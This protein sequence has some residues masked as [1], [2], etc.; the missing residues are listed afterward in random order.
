MFVPIFLKQI[1]SLVNRQ[2]DLREPH[3]CTH[4]SSVLVN[5]SYGYEVKC[6]AVNPT[7][8]HYI[9]VGCD[10]CFVRLYDRRMVPT[11]RFNLYVSVNISAQY[12]N[13]FC[14][15]KNLEVIKN[16]FNKLA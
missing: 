15:L 10:D 7:K 12:F 8:P 16:I 9:A 1:F 14:E 5:L 4:Q 2:Y 6:I 3:T 13:S 11:I